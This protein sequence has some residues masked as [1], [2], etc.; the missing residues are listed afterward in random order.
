M[1]SREESHSGRR[2]WWWWCSRWLHLPACCSWSSPRRQQGLPQHRWP[3]VY[4][5]SSSLSQWGWL[6]RQ[7]WFHQ[8]TR[9]LSR[10]P[11]WRERVMSARLPMRNDEAQP[12]HVSQ[13]VVLTSWLDR[14][15]QSGKP[16]VLAMSFT[17]ALCWM[18]WTLARWPPRS[19]HS[20]RAS[21]QFNLRVTTL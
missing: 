5:S 13:T 8:T 11:A 20:S 4:W 12:E 21:Y 17:W 14:P 16:S 19:P 18:S 7:T 3:P 15:I 2:W 1:Y 6:C 10:S 9:R